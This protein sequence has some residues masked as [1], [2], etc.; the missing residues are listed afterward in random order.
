MNTKMTDANLDR[1]VAT[2]VLE[3]YEYATDGQ[4]GDEYV[5]LYFVGGQVLTIGANVGENG[6]L[7][8]SDT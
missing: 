7:N 2:G 8:F 5:V 4:W 6:W 1:L 3:K